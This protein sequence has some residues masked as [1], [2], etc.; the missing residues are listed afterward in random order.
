M[1]TRIEE[2]FTVQAPIDRVWSYLVDPR[3]PYGR[4]EMIRCGGP[5]G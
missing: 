4:H 5:H 3:Q 2:R 1:P